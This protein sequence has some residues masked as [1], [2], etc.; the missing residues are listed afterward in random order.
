MRLEA[1]GALSPAM[2]IAAPFAAVALTLVVA[3]L[4]VAWAGAPVGRTYALIFEGGFG[5]RFAWSE[6][7]TRATPLMLTGLA[8]A[9]AFRAHLYNIGAEGQLAFGGVLW[10]WGPVM[11]LTLGLLL[12]AERR[13][14]DTPRTP[15]R[16]MRRREGA[17]SG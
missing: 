3:A 12:R 15:R 16:P 1:R 11:L 5:S 2:A 8:V 14:A 4:F 6:T 13:A 17:T 7:L 10:V 9:I